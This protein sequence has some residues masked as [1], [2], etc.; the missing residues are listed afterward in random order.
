MKSMPRKRR[1]RDFLLAERDVASA[2]EATGLL[3]SFPQDRL[4]RLEF[5]QLYALQR[6]VNRF[7]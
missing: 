3:P 2:N 1:E 5:L 7:F 6:D 4:S